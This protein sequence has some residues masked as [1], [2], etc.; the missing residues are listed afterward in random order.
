MHIFDITTIWTG[1]TISIRNI[2][3]SAGS[4]ETSFVADVSDSAGT[5]VGTV[6]GCSDRASI[7]L[8]L[9][10]VNQ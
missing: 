3:P 1:H 2:N 10:H 7:E 5:L 6:V 8:S 9:A 4:N